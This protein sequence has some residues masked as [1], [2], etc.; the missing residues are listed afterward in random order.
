MIVNLWEQS[1]EFNSLYRQT[2]APFTFIGVLKEQTTVQIQC[3]GGRGMYNSTEIFP[4]R[5]P[6][7]SMEREKE[8]EKKRQAHNVEIIWHIV[9]KPKKKKM[10]ILSK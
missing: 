10:F 8:R 5:E 7:E 4:N 6:D 1:S 2:P 3:L 9:C